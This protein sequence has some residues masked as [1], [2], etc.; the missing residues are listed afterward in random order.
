MNEILE[1]EQW[2]PFLADVTTAQHGDA[3]AI[4]IL[5]D[6]LGDQPEADGLPLAS[7]GYDRGDDAVIVELSST[8][9][10]KKIV[11]RR[12]IMSPTSVAASPPTPGKVRAI[13]VENEDGVTLVGLRP[14]NEIA[15]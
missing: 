4:E 11:L 14:F 10:P 9:D 1:P 15:G 12:I 3:T 6:A 13:R 5:S 8:D 2:E 7:V